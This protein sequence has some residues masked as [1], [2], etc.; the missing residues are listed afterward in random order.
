MLS[1]KD[2]PCLVVGGGGVALRKVQS[3]VAEGA[4]VTVIAP[5]AVEPLE[6]MA[7][8]AE[9]VLEARAYRDGEAADFLL[10]FAATDRRDVNRRVF[11]DAERGGVWANVADDPELCSFHLPARVQ[12]GPFQ[13]AVASAGTAPFAVRRVRQLLEHRFGPEWGEWIEAAARFRDDV[14]AEHLEP[15]EQEACFERFFSSTVRPDRLD[16]RVPTAAEQSA[17][18]AETRG[19]M[20]SPK[21]SARRSGA[22]RPAPRSTPTGHVSL[23][24]AGPGCA[25]L[26]TVR[27]RKRLLAADAVVYDRLAAAALPCDLPYHVELHGVGKTAGHHPVPQEEI[28]E[29]LVRLAGQGKR[30]VR[31][32]GGDPYVFGRGGEEAER[33]AAEG[34]PFEVVPGVTSGVAAPAWIGVPVTHRAE[35]VRLTLLTAH[36]SVKR[37]GPQVRWDLLAQDPHATLVGYMGVTTLSKVVHELLAYGMD[38]TTPAA[39]IQDGTLATQRSVIATLAEL[40]EAVRREAI[41]PPALFVI[42]PTVR[43]A[44]DLDWHGRQP[45]RGERLVLFP[46]SA[47]LADVLEAAGAEVVI[48]PTPISPATRVVIGAAPLSGC[49]LRSPAEVDAL[50]DERDGTGWERRPVAWC[51]GSDTAQ[52]ALERGWTDVRECPRGQDSMSLMTC[53]AGAR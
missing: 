18:I 44:A 14:R 52:R 24:G 9:I 48:A 13:L 30:V 6:A 38:P 53:I 51:V 7:R 26:I 47:D 45:L 12:R 36:E 22:P 21:D 46:S 20:A 15:A 33:L 8:R 2:R 32:K 25:G 34:V 4:R 42:G 41:E 31:L 28:T 49:V 5:Q 23:V 50:E 3:L 39:M 37:K 27:G 40:P 35:A 11:E 1:V 17:W 43:H 19:A 29:L 16:A 10:V